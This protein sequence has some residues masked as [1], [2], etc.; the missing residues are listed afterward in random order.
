[1]LLLM[2]C[3]ILDNLKIFQTDIMMHKSLAWS[4]KLYLLDLRQFEDKRESL[5]SWWAILPQS[6]HRSSSST[7]CKNKHKHTSNHSLTSPIKRNKSCL[8]W[9]MSLLD[10][11][12]LRSFFPWKL[13]LSVSF[14]FGKNNFI[15]L[16]NSEQI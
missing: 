16:W 14:N 7:N 6:S 11:L 9:F 5:N 1:M 13:R 8:N 12:V 4:E 10:I 3:V 15:R 2:R